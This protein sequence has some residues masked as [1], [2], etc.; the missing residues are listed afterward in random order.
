[1]LTDEKLDQIIGNVLRGGVLLSFVIVA[2][3]GFMFLL[4]HHADTQPFARFSGAAG[5][6]TLGEIWQSVTRFDSGGIIQLGLVVLIATPVVR[7]V[8]A[9]AGFALIGDR[10]YSFVSLIVL[11]ILVYSITHTLG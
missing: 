4:Q 10:M 8:M 3:G 9:G 5:L 7:V 2:T 11:A 6:Q 1:M